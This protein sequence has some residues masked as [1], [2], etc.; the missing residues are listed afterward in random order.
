MDND[1]SFFKFLETVLRIE[2]AKN[3]Q[4]FPQLI[5]KE[6][7]RRNPNFDIRNEDIDWDELTLCL[8]F[9]IRGYCEYYSEKNVIEIVLK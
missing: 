8:S 1:E 9:T 7:L 2:L 4:N 6:F 3:Q 5:L